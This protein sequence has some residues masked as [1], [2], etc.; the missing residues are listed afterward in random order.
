MNDYQIIMEGLQHYAETMPRL[1]ALYKVISVDQEK[2]LSDYT[3]AW[4]RLRDTNPEQLDKAT[5]VFLN[6]KKY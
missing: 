3:K 6:G 5:A 1:E 4:R 2:N